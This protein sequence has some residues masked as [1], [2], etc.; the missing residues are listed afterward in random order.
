MSPVS[1][2]ASR[3]LRFSPDSDSAPPPLPP[4]PSIWE[5]AAQLPG[6]FINGGGAG[7]AGGGAGGGQYQAVPQFEGYSARWRRRSVELSMVGSGANVGLTAVFF[8]QPAY[9][10]PDP[11]LPRPSALVDPRHFS[12]PLSLPSISPDFSLSIRY[13]TTVC[14]AFELT[15]SRTDAD[16]CA[17]A[18]ALHP[19][20]DDAELEAWMKDRLGPD[21]FNVQIEGAERLAKDVPD[22]YREGCSYEFQFRLNNAGK[23]WMN[24]T[25]NFEDFQAFFEI[26]AKEQSRPKPRMKMVPLVAQPLELDLCPSTCASYVPPRLGP[27]SSLLATVLADPSTFSSSISQA[28]AFFRKPA[29][30]LSSLD[31]LPSCH[32]AHASSSSVVGS[33]VPAPYLDL[34]HPRYRLPLDAR[35]TRPTAGLYSFVPAQCRWTHAGQRFRDHTSC[36][37]R[38]HNAFLIG[39]SHARAVFDVVKHRLEGNDSV[40]EAS[41]KALS[42]SAHVGNLYM[43][44]M[45]DPYLKAGMACDFIT[46]FDSI[47]VSSGTHQICWNCPRTASLLSS[48]RAVLTTWPRQIHE[49]HARSGQTQ[50]KSPRLIFLTMPPFHPQLHNRDCRTGARIAYTNQRLAEIA[51]EA[52]W[53]VLDIERYV[54]PVAVDQ[55]VGDGVHYLRLDAAE[56]IADDFIDRLGIC[57]EEDAPEGREDL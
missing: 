10:C 20:S 19:A 8:R 50:A 52:G 41:P 35:Y 21:G 45:W 3:D 1:R 37:E 29:S 6:E 13:S 46:K 15:I 11:R 40:A 5:R 25:L 33:Y 14:N 34:V 18:E 16:K 24:V 12:P 57:G 26:D 36:L 30:S 27:P 51:E 44:F 54:K 47:T 56:P 22:R 42:K 43:E 2:R 23:V 4:K 32:R 48:L 7:G 31:N 55:L 9:T 53:E 28:L 49:C 38:E 17:T 39:D